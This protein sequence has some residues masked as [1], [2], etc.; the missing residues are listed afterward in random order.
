MRGVCLRTLH[1]HGSGSGG[2]AG[3]RTHLQLVCGVSE[4]QLTQHIS[5]LSSQPACRQADRPATA[6]KS[7]CQKHTWTAQQHSVQ[8]CCCCWAREHQASNNSCQCPVQS[9]D[10]PAQSAV[11]SVRLLHPMLTPPHT[12]THALVDL[13]LPDVDHV[14]RHLHSGCQQARAALLDVLA[15]NVEVHVAVQHHLQ[16]T[17]TPPRGSNSNAGIVCVCECLCRR[18]T[19]QH[20]V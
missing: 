14:I 4:S 12:H 5:L 1:R 13:H 3:C 15:V 19:T 6:S 7:G 11:S 2:A 8:S 9:P 10:A 20:A 17:C 18:R 16:G